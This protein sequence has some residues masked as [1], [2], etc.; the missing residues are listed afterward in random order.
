MMMIVAVVAFIAVFIVAAEAF[1]VVINVAVVVILV[2]G[3][4]GISCGLLLVGFFCVNFADFDVIVVV[5]VILS[6][7]QHPLYA[8][9]VP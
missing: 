1:A 7:K 3:G 2:A 8:A 5:V 4:S 6:L 9:G